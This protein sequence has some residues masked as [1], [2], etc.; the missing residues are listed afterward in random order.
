MFNAKGDILYVGKAKNLKNRLQ[1][2]FRSTGLSVKTQALVSKIANIEVTPT[3]SEIEA[4]LL[5]QGLIKS[6]KPPYNILL[7]DDKSYP[8]ILI[9]D[10]QYPRIDIHRGAKRKKG[11]Y[12][13]PYPSSGAVRQSLQ[14]LQ[15]TFL[16]RPCEDSVFSNR[17]R[18]C[19]QYQIKRCSAPCMGAEYVDPEY[20]AMQIKHAELFLKGE[21]KQLIGDLAEQM[22]Q[23]SSSLAFEKAAELRDQISALQQLQ[24]EQVAETG[25]SNI[26]VISCQTQ[27]GAACIHVLYIRSGRVLGS[28]SYFP[29]DALAGTAETLLSAFIPQ[30]YLNQ[31]NRDYPREIVLDR[32]LEDSE[33]IEQA[34]ATACN[35][36]IS[37][38]HNVIGHR[39]KWIQLAASA[40]EQNLKTRITSKEN[41]AGRFEALRAVLGMEEVPMR[42][43][44]YDISHTQGE[45]TVG[46]CVVFDL[47]GPKKADYRQYNVEDIVGGDDYAAMRQVLTRRYTR[48]QKGEGKLPDILIV[49]GGKGQLNQ[50]R[51]VF[52]ELGVTNVVLLGV[53]KGTTRKAGFE[54]LYLETV[55]GEFTL[56]S[57]SPALH[58]IQHIRDE[59]HRFCI[60]GHKNRRDKARKASVL[61]GVAG[62]GPKRRKELLRHFGGLQEIQAAGI[63]DLAKIPSINK[64]LAEDIYSAL[65]SE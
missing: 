27:A 5:E 60:T 58:L 31:A 4:L 15:R 7:R 47:Q 50:A 52:E 42:L 51:A 3:R 54:T 39:A 32:S 44:C 13:G 49:D 46:A 55:A 21:D 57:D 48:L 40:A 9:T 20:Y 43:E 45:K 53:A 18:P 17:S 12:F 56:D 62:V 24:S 19:L 26:D 41:M 37:I 14:F 30:Y 28:R 2:Y 23:A 25:S 6:Q 29:K 38:T 65:H 16:L 10:H 8:Y 64:K 59:A 35:R 34:L 63:D 22:E 61:E 11:L 36:K 33:L 1:S